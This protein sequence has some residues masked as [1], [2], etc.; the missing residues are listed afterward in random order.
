[1][2]HFIKFL[3]Y[4]FHLRAWGQFPK[5]YP[6]PLSWLLSPP[7]I[8]ALNDLPF[9]PRPTLLPRPILSFHWAVCSYRQK[10]CSV[11]HSFIT[12]SMSLNWGL[13]PRQPGFSWLSLVF[14]LCPLTAGIG[15]CSSWQPSSHKVCTSP[16]HLQGHSLGSSRIQLK[17]GW[18]PV[19]L[20][21]K[22]GYIMV[23][24]VCHRLRGKCK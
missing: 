1:M 8:L 13:M 24:K 6:T 7:S 21:W 18:D 23:R 12:Y 19:R 4:R 11:I 9:P 22:R 20:E 5:Y 2:T 15:H 10:L 17:K 16:H 14:T 3:F